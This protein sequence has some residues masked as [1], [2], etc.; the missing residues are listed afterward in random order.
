MRKYI[1]AFMKK[2]GPVRG[3]VSGIRERVRR[4]DRA[5]IRAEN[6][7]RADQGI[8]WCK[9]LEKSLKCAITRS[10]IIIGE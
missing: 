9:I 2:T 4:D 8:R 3:L 10:I 1:F 6:R 7:G 5:I